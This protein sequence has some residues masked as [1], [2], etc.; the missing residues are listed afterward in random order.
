[1]DNPNNTD[2]AALYPGQT[3][4]VLPFPHFPVMCRSTL[5]EYHMAEVI[6]V[7]SSFGLHTFCSHYPSNPLANQPVPSIMSHITAVRGHAPRYA[8]IVREGNTSEWE[9]REPVEPYNGWFNYEELGTN[10]TWCTPAANLLTCVCPS[11]C[12]NPGLFWKSTLTSYL[13]D[14][15][16]NPEFRLLDFVIGAMNW[17]A[18]MLVS[19][20]LA[21][22]VGAKT[23]RV[24][25]GKGPKPGKGPGRRESKDYMTMDPGRA[26]VYACGPY[27]C[28]R[29]PETV[30]WHAAPA[31][32]LTSRDAHSTVMQGN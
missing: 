22:L 32:V 31:L 10:A 23:P 25:Q 19:L 7:L 16:I 27:L 12:E 17:T 1:M 28:S 18:D 5:Q 6:F 8:A 29:Y 3:R 15:H 9:K 11:R 20:L 26:S 4:L 30:H 21:P 14:R 2:I 13:P 24:V